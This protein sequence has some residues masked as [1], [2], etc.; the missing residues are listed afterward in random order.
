M[1]LFTTTYLSFKR[2]ES[3]INY[4]GIAK[5]NEYNIALKHIFKFIIQIYYH[6]YERLQTA[7]GLVIGFIEHL[8][9]QLVNTSNYS[10]IA[11]VHTLQITRAHAKSYQCAFH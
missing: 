4:T 3:R 8:H 9:A 7:S 6:V 2:A 5:Q 10:T 11:N 1:S